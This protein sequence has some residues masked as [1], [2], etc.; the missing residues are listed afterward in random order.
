M[1]C[2]LSVDSIQSAVRVVS[3][4][5]FGSVGSPIPKVRK[6]MNAPISRVSQRERDLWVAAGRA[7]HSDHVE[8]DDETVDVSDEALDDFLSGGPI[9]E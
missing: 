8:P 2:V 5:G 4:R 9:P 3:I 1:V 7:G 6:V